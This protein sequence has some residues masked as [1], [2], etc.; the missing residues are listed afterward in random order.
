[1]A[2]AVTITPAL[3]RALIPAIV[4]APPAGS[5]TLPPAPPPAPPPTA[6]PRVNALAFSASGD[7]AFATTNAGQLLVLDGQT[8]EL[9]A[10]LACSDT[11]CRAV[12]ATHA[13]RAVLY[14]SAP[15]AAGGGFAGAA[16]TAVL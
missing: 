3:A 8:G 13:E 11:G 7:G 6:D 15:P 10:T 2:T 9:S 5:A 4:H 1:M 12:T 14:A 16:G